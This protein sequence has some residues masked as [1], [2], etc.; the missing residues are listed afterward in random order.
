MSFA[1][2]TTDLFQKLLSEVTLWTK[3]KAI[4]VHRLDGTIF[5]ITQ[6]CAGDVESAYADRLRLIHCQPTVIPSKVHTKITPLL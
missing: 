2:I 6:Q 5:V 4:C 1:R 3:R